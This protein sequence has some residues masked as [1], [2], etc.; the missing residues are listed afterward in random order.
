MKISFIVMTLLMSLNG[1]ASDC[2]PYQDL[3][4]ISDEFSQFDKFVRK[5]QA[6]YCEKD[7]GEQ[8]FKIGK[9]L[10]LLKNISPNEPALDQQDGFTYKAISEKDWWSYFTNR[11]RKFSI[12]SNCREGVVAYVRP[13][14]G[15][16]RINLCPFFFE[17]NISSQASVMMHEVRHFDGH[18]HTRCT[19]GNENGMSGACDSKI[20]SGG[21]Y[22]ISVQTLVGMARSNDIP[23]SE[24]ALVEAESVYMAFNKFNT[25]PKLK[26]NR[27]MVLSNGIG[28][29]YNWNLETNETTLMKTL[30]NPAKVLASGNFMTLYP[31]DTNLD[32]YRKSA[33]LNEIIEKPGLFAEAYNADTL[34]ERDKYQTVNYMGS[35]GYLKDNTLYTLCNRRAGTI[36]STNLDNKGQFTR[37]LSISKRNAPQ[38]IENFLL[39]ESGDLLSFECDGI[40]SS[41]VNFGKIKKTINSDLTKIE[42]MISSGEQHFAIKET[43][44]L[45]Q[46]ERRGQNLSSKMLSQ[47]PLDN[48]DWIS[49]APQARPEVFE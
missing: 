6:E 12:Q 47:F 39:S 33:D 21:S 42:Q 11:A 41:K 26:I 34:T 13:F 18:G 24:K 36:D 20:T 9:S 16:G 35:G 32:A 7:L 29:V 49:I 22:A 28:E 43:G 44:E 1:Y 4:E 45:I 40:S 17:F 30:E 27:A 25:V 19:Q 15:G 48:N 2:I 5:K 38:E 23:E 37:I 46:V 8:W 14:F 10:E 31:V 3:K